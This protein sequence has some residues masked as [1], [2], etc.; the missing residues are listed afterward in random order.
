MSGALASKPMDELS[1]AE[2]EGIAAV[3]A[4]L[5]SERRRARIEAV[6]SARTRALTLVMEEVYSDHNSAAILRTADIFGLLDVHHVSATAELRLSR[7]VALGSEKWLNLVGHPGPAAAFETLRDQGFEIWSAA[8]HGRSVE[9]DA[10]PSDRPLA[11]VFGNELE[12]LSTYAQSE[13]DGRFH[14]PMRGFAESY[15]VSVAAA[16]TLDRVLRRRLPSPLSP[17][18]QDRLRACYYAR[19]VRAAPQLLSEA[20]LPLAELGRVETTWVQR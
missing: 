19:S 7:K 14:L 20:G 15:N 11:L 4:P 6:V 8:V 17:E 5:V 13:A 10:L 2:A 12:G 18:E 3:L 1:L 16:L 9:V